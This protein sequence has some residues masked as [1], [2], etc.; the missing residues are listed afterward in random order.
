MTDQQ[1]ENPNNTKQ[2]RIVFYLLSIML[3]GNFLY[4]MGVTANE[5]PG[6]TVQVMEMVLDA[7]SIVGLI[8]TR[9]CGH[10]ILF[11]VAL[12]A[13]IGLFAIR[14]HSDASWWTG[15]WNYALSR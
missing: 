7:A 15:H 1:A 6:R 12:I 10:Q 2:M 11:V 13:G 14:L 5:Y 9:K 8:G 4:R 3:I